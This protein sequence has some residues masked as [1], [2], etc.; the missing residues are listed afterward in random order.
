M[1]NPVKDIKS[2]IVG[3][4]MRNLVLI[5]SFVLVISGCS[6]QKEQQKEDLASA[7]D[8]VISYKLNAVEEEHAE[9]LNQWLANA[10]ETGEIGQ[11]FIYQDG[12][13]KEDLYSYVY[14]KGYTDYEVSFIYD[15]SDPNNKGKIHVT[16]INKDLKND[17]FVQIKS[18]NDLLI[19]FILS[20]ESLKSK[21]KE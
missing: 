20:D 4:T 3:G 17:N 6:I 21:L 5:L 19:L 13:N 11:Y 2:L 10:R 16:G 12:T 15:P 9:K 14:R 8:G 7:M 18:I 1:R